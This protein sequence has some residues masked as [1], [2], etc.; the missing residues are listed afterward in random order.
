MRKDTA[1]TLDSQG[2]ASLGYAGGI[3]MLS[4]TNTQ[5]VPRLTPAITVKNGLRPC[6]PMR[7]N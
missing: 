1:H 5:H 2:S 6:G 7:V 4:V 3:Y